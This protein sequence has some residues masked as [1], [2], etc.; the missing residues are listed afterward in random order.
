MSTTKSFKTNMCPIGVIIDGY[1]KSLSYALIQAKVWS[2]SQLTAH[3][4]QI[5][6]LQDL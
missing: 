4:P 5:P 3:E 6:S 1:A 2:P